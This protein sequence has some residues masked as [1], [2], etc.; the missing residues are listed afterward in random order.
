MKNVVKPSEQKV[1]LVDVQSEKLS[2]KHFKH[3]IKKLSEK[4]INE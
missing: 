4:Y 1:V 2:V 3:P